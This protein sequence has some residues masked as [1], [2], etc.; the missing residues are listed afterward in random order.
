MLHSASHRTRREESSSGYNIHHP[1]SEWDGP[2]EGQT[3]RR[4]LIRPDALLEPWHTRFIR[5][6]RSAIVAAMDS[7][8]REAAVIIARNAGR[9]RKSAAKYTKRWRAK[10]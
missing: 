3:G 6:R 9:S 10:A 2:R 8:A 7:A 1:W 5:R 4:I